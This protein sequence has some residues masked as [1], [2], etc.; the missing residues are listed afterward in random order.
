ME[1]GSD[2]PYAF[3]RM[4]MQEKY[5]SCISGSEEGLLAALY[6]QTLGAAARDALEKSA[7]ALGY[8]PHAVTFVQMDAGSCILES[9]QVLELIEGLDPLCIV[10]ADAASWKTCADI[11]RMPLPPFARCRLMGREARG[12]DN[13]DSLMESSEG[14]QRVWAALKTLPACPDPR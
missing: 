9:T 1:H 2:N 12:F 14:K 3:S 13:L 10:A 7:E 8:G 5:A 4:K 6:H 11:Y